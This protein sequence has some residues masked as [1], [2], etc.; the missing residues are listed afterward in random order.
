MKFNPNL[1]WL[2]VAAGGAQAAPQIQEVQPWPV[3]SPTQLVIWGE[4]FGDNPEIFLGTS[5][6]PLAM[7]A[8]Q[9]L[10]PNP[11]EADAP[12]LDST[13]KD[14]VVVDLPIADNGEPSVPAGD[15]LLRVSGEAVEV[16][17][18]KP[19]AL[20]FQYVPNS[21]PGNN[22]QG[23]ECSGDPLYT[24]DGNVTLTAEGSNNS[25]WNFYAP[26]G[27]TS[28]IYENSAE[29]APDGFIAI[30]KDFG[31]KNVPNNLTL[32]METVNGYSQTVSIHTSC[33][34]PLAIGDVFGSVVLTDMEA[35]TA[36]KT[37]TALYDLTLGA[38]GPQGEPGSDGEP[39]ANGDDGKGW[40]DATGRWS[41]D[42]SQYFVSFNHEDETFNWETDNIRG[43]QGPKGDN[44][45]N[46]LD[47][48]KALVVSGE[49]ETLEPDSPA[50]VESEYDES[51]NTTTLSFF[52][53]A[54]EK[55]DTGDK[56]D[57][58]PIGETGAT[59]EQGPQGPVGETGP[60]GPIGETGPQGAIGE[61]GPQGAIG[62]TGPQGPIGETG[63][64]GPIG[65]TGPQG[66]IGE[67]GPQGPIGET[68]PQGPIGE[69]GP[70]GPIGETGPQGPVG[71]TGPQGPQ[72]P[73]GPQGLKG[74]TGETGAT[75]PQGP[76][77]ETGATGPQ[78]PAGE[79]G[80]T[81][82]Q[83]PT[84]ETGAAGPQGPAGETG[85]TGLQ[86]PAGETGPVGPQGPTGG[87][88]AS[89][90]CFSTD[91]TIGAQGKFMGL[92]TQ[93]G[94][95]TSV[96]VILPAF[97]G[98][99]TV[100]DFT[101]KVAQ[102]NTALDGEAW[103]IHDNGIADGEPVTEVCPIVADPADAGRS[104]VCDSAAP[105]GIALDTNDSLS[106]YVK[107]NGGSF[108]GAS[109]CVLVTPAP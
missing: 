48:E 43:P 7:A 80:A 54:G 17:M 37:V 62:E 96:S 104:T 108:A 95:H 4:Q 79:T 15:Y 77:G 11:L 19:G 107:T 61:T 58:G 87:T 86:G 56:G 89:L 73:E 45:E 16:C 5:S 72:G 102:G 35:E 39:G 25:D 6:A 70:Q 32:T 90:L 55:G 98:A 52:V 12:P 30:E 78:G 36:P 63:P 22:L 100:S 59:G 93:G 23:A 101:V 34:E 83:G 10:C 99:G 14:C 50:R 65:E 46:G 109:A 27:S 18:S 92:G 42:E 3:D 24:D 105:L 94:D 38:V 88:G 31:S 57:Q 76:A 53:P 47:G 103:V 74:D 81:G 91:Q 67:T 49:T 69:T 60:Q 106:V 82:P 33:S 26:E 64:Q 8:E 1:L 2:A 51:T 40:T 29:V 75:G 85:A 97:Y 41:E 9:S 44:G 13:G 84:G 21:C 68:G 71:E 28:V 20:M 66:P